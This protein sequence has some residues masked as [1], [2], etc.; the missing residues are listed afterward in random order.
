M[1]DADVEPLVLLAGTLCD[2]RVFEPVLARLPPRPVIAPAMRGARTAADL[3][4]L[5]LENLP[6][7]FALAGF[8]L[9]GIVA[10][11]MIARAP[12][13]V[14]RLALIDTTARA[15]PPENRRARRNAVAR[16]AEVGVERYVTH[17]L[18]SLYVSPDQ[19]A[20]AENR[21]LVGAM[22]AAGGLAAF[23]EQSEVAINRADSR[24]RLP[25]IAVPTLVLC[26]EAERLCP[27][28]VHREM[29]AAIPGARLA[30]IPNAGHFALIEQ[31]G[32][33]AAEFGRWLAAPARPIGAR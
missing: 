13:R 33:V 31:P 19:T 9:G 14:A 32:A 27:P 22:S 17:K 21:A 8:S 20:N 15:D 5:L 4:R 18:W 23:D 26:G 2:I 16:A 30:I 29:A 10:L 1:G 11:E 24:P 3:A 12:E 7:R 28:E 25:A 6:P